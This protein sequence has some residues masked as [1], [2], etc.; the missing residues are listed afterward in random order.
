MITKL[1]LVALGFVFAFGIGLMALSGEPAGLVDQRGDKRS[2]V[3]TLNEMEQLT[4]GLLCPHTV[5]A[6]ATCLPLSQGCEYSECVRGDDSERDRCFHVEMLATFVCQSEAG[7]NKEC[8][9]TAT[10]VFCA[11]RYWGN[12]DVWWGVCSPCTNS[13]QNCSND[14]QVLANEVECVSSGL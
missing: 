13:G 12:Y 7:S 3:L 6:S 14:P 2:F 5:R 10:G 4:A 1:R 8:S 11:K 9:T